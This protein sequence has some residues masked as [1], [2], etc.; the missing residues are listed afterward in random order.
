MKKIGILP[1]SGACNV[2][3]LS[4]KAVVEMFDEYGN[5]DFVCALGL[6]LGIEGI[7]KNGKSSDGYIALN[8]CPVKCATKALESADIPIDDEVVITENFNIKKNKNLKSDEK[9]D[10]ILDE[11]KKLIDKIEKK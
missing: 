7:I 11:L 6:P 5:V 10:Q 9:M 8:G 4:T 1:C 3:M 2:G